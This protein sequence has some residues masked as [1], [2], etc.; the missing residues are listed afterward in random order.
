MR[1][2]LIADGTAAL[3]R[4]LRGEDREYRVEWVSDAVASRDL[5]TPSDSHPNPLDDTHLLREHASEHGKSHD[6]EARR[7]AIR[8]MLR[9][10]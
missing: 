4:L 7:Q 9:D 1:I 10:A 2:K 8:E 5:K 6:R 3:R